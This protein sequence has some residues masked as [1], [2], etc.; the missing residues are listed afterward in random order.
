MKAL[1]MIKIIFSSVLILIN[2]V[3]FAQVYQYSTI[4][5]LISGNYDG[6]LTVQEILQQ[7]SVGLGTFNTLDGELVIEDGVAYQA[8]SDS[9][10]GSQTQAVS[11]ELKIPFGVV[12]NFKADTSFKLYNISA[13]SELEKILDSLLSGTNT[14]FVIKVS[15]S[16]KNLT[17]RSVAPQHKPYRRLTEAVKDQVF[18]NFENQQG[19]LVGFHF[20][21]YMQNINV[22]GYH[23]HYLS[24]DKKRGGHLMKCSIDKVSF[25]VDYIN[26]FR[27][28]LPKNHFLQNANLSVKKSEELSIEKPK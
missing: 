1:F 2:N 9:S 17:V 15:G 8:K 18:F 26:D 24:S 21:A 11:G 6:E 5:S 13:I 27:M 3:C 28:I 19:T 12:C 25:D 22:T 20:P 14:I 23:W 7:G 10:M 4:N 16:F